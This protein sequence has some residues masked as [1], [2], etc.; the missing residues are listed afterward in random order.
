MSI[1]SQL[2]TSLYDSCVA[3]LSNYYPNTPIIFSHGSGPEPNVPYITLQI[4]SVEQMGRTQTATRADPVYNEDEEITHYVLNSQGHYEVTVQFSGV[5]SNAGGLTFDFHH[6]LNTTLVW[7]KFQINSLY[8]IR[9][10]DV[11]RAPMLRET[12]WVER[13]NFDVV[14][15]YSVSTNQT[16]DVIEYYTLTRESTGQE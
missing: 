13:Y 3:G 7:E 1:Y 15:T 2:E 14:F 5:G 10:T 4:L 16:V 12:Q 6:L 11:R 9:K 8:P